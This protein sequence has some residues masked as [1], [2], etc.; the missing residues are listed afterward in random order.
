M[1]L[2]TID[3]LPAV[4]GLLYIHLKPAIFLAGFYSSSDGRFVYSFAVHIHGIG[5]R[6]YFAATKVLQTGRLPKL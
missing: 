2:Y 5:E 4:F 6:L 3:G 1:V